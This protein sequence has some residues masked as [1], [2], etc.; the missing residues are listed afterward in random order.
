LPDA[1]G[2]E[3]NTKAAVAGGGAGTLLLV[4]ANSLPASESLAQTVLV[5][6][7]PAVSVICTAAW[8][9]L[10]AWAVKVRKRRLVDSALRRAIAFRDRVCSDPSASDAHKADVRNKVEHFE[11]L[12][13]AL[14]ASEFDS[15]DA[16]LN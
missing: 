11:K 13:M 3:L 6:S 16:K 9:L 2:R 7:A 14:I 4:L 5:Y 10:A 1:E 12:A 8:V 15:V